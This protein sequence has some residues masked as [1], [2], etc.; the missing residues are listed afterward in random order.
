MRWIKARYENE[1][2][3][4]PDYHSFG[5]PLA[6]WDGGG[7]VG[8]DMRLL[9]PK[10]NVGDVIVFYGHK[11]LVIDLNPAAHAYIIMTDTP[12]ANR[13][14]MFN[15]AEKARIEL[16]LWALWFMEH[17]IYNPAELDAI[18]DRLWGEPF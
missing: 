16:R 7:L 6:E 17:L 15:L 18:Y 14:L 4:Y 10:A 9:Q 3:Y 13:L 5:Q 12:E 8:L 11:L 1:P 2:V